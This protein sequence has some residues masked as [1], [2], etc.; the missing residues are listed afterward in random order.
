MLRD[1]LGGVFFTSDVVGNS[2]NPENSKTKCVVITIFLLGY[3]TR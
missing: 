2:P 3:I 1:L